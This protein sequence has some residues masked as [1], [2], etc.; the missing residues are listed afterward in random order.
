MVHFRTITEDNFDAVINMK[1]PEGEGFVASNA[2]SLARPGS[3]GTTEM[4][5]PLPSMTTIPL[6]ASCLWRRIWTRSGWTCSA[7]CCL[8]S[9]KAGVW[10]QRLWNC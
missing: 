10:A 8:P 5:F 6:W 2:V 7:L 3:T 4:C 1:R 9:G